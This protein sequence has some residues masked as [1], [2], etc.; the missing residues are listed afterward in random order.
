MQLSQI[1]EPAERSVKFENGSYCNKDIPLDLWRSLSHVT[2]WEWITPKG[3]LQG[4][5]QAV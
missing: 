1:G 2:A 4:G 3:H 5:E